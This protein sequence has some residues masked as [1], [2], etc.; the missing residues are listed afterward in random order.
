M[1]L[2][3]DKELVIFDLDGTLVKTQFLHEKAYSLA[4]D[5]IWQQNSK[6]SDK[7]LLY[8]MKCKF[9]LDLLTSSELELNLPVYNLY[10]LLKSTNKKLALAT[11]TLEVNA[12]AI[13]EKLGLDFDL[14]LTGDQ[15][16]NNNKPAPDMFLKACEHFKIGIYNTIVIEDSENGFMAAK[17]AN[18]SYI[19]ANNLECQ[20]LL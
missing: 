4:K 10:Q 1:S 13:I 20:N 9:Y 12:Y 18:I 17:A 8:K 14:V 7:D 15:F 2:F 6:N 5:W 11:S 19:D 16:K 3:E